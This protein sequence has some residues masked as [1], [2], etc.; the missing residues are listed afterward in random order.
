MRRSSMKCFTLKSGHFIVAGS[1]SAMI[2]GHGYTVVSEHYPKPKAGIELDR[3]DRAVVLGWQ[4]RIKVADELLALAGHSGEI[5]R[6]GTTVTVLRASLDTASG[7]PV[8]VPERDD[9][10]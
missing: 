9:D 4:R 3:S 1:M 8:L 10:K 6:E 5:T 2:P 7:E